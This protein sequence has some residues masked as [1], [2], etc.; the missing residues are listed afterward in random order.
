MIIERIG[1]ATGWVQSHLSG[2]TEPVVMFTPPPHRLATAPISTSMGLST[3]S[4][5]EVRSG[6][7]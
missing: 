5:P 1:H 6:E 7:E 4:V 2:M 3:I